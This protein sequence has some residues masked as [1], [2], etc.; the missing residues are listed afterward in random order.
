[1]ATSRWRRIY[2]LTAGL[3]FFQAASHGVL[4]RAQQADAMAN[5]SA[6]ASSSGSA[7]ATPTSQD[8]ANMVRMLD[9]VRQQL[10]DEHQ[11]VEDLRNEVRE[12]RATVA[13]G[14]SAAAVADSLKT[15]VDQLH[16]DQ[17][18][19]QSQI[20]TLQQTK[21]ETESK[22]PLTINGMVL[23]NSFVVDGAVDNPV[24]PLIALQRNAYYVHHSLGGSLQQTQMGLSATGPHLW[25]ARTSAD[26][27]TDFFNQTNYTAVS[28]GGTMSLRLRTADVNLDWDKTQISVGLQTPLISLLSPT[29]FATVGEPALSWSGNLWTW[30]PQVTIERR[31]SVAG[32]SHAVFGFGVLDPSTSDILGEQAYG[33]LRR[34]VQPGYE[35]RSSYQW[36]DPQRPYEIGVNG[37]YTRQLYSLAQAANSQALDFWAGTADW[38]LPVAKFAD[39]SGEF[40]RG[41]GIGDLGGGAF[42]NVVLNYTGTYPRGLDSTGGWAQLKA[43]LNRLTEV[44]AY[45]GVD[46]ANADET[47]Y[48]TTMATTSPY[49]YLVKNR[50]VAANII[51]RPQTYL[52]FSAEYRDLRSWY[53]I[54][55][56]QY[57]QTLNLT[58]GYIF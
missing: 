55:P 36:G 39:L 58:M 35:A 56:S 30:L 38:R 51:F 34:T 9:E 21:V 13:S 17:E 12:L 37:Y 31:I 32:S 16:D 4:L 19:V 26:F 49:F 3:L 10:R 24:L 41:H 40:Y 14:G 42:K 22:Y 54:G 43:K 27:S 45:A 33:T 18:L 52:V 29:S 2:T 6:A 20:K 53:V 11:Q 46:S 50:T 15:A 47:R 57:A 28:A 25:G 7:A 48:G 44:N 1:M 5:Q 23:F 8:M